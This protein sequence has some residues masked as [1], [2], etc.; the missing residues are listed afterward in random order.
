MLYVPYACNNI[1]SYIYVIRKQNLRLN[2]LKGLK[3]TMFKH[4]IEALFIN[5]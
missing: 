3:I 1:I 4:I 2:C 5:E